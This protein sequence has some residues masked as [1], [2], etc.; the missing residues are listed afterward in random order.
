VFVDQIHYR[1]VTSSGVQVLPNP[2]YGKP[3]IFQP[4]AAFRLGAELMW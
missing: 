1:A 3:L 2:N 4:P